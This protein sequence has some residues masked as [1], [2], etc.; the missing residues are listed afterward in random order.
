MVVTVASLVSPNPPAEVQVWVCFEASADGV[1]PAQQGSTQA[2]EESEWAD[3]WFGGVH[4]K[5]HFNSAGRWEAKTS[6]I[7]G[8][9]QNLSVGFCRKAM[10]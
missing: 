10:K 2:T 3:T 8:I 7:C 1:I 4:K 9:V 6:D 5:L